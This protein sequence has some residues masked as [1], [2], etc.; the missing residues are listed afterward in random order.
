MA[1]GKLPQRLKLNAGGAPRKGG[2]KP[3]AA[4]WPADAQPGRTEAVLAVV[5]AGCDRCD[6]SIF[7]QRLVEWV[8]DELA[9]RDGPQVKGTE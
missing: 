5:Q 4:P 6:K 8:K 3:W 1:K 7:G 2:A 9:Q